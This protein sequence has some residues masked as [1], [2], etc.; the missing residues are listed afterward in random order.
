[1]QKLNR[2]RFTFVLSNCYNLLRFHPHAYSE[3]LLKYFRR[4]CLYRL[5]FVLASN[6]QSFVRQTFPIRSTLPAAR[7]VS[8]PLQCSPQQKKFCCPYRR[9]TVSAV[10]LPFYP[11][12]PIRLISHTDSLF[13]E[14]LYIVLICYKSFCERFFAVKIAVVRFRRGVFRP[15]V[16]LPGDGVVFGIQSFVPQNYVIFVPRHVSPQ[17][18]DSTSVTEYPTF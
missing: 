10:V 4:F 3:A 17:T 9:Q 1:M 6:S 13:Y 2:H 8:H 15:I 18:K 12:E 5:Y 14:R 7:R 16:I 11:S